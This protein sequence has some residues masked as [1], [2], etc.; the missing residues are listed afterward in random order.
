MESD[1]KIFTEELE[2]NK[3]ENTLLKNKLDK[4]IKNNLGIINNKQ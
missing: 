4:E 1:L 3:N 2:K